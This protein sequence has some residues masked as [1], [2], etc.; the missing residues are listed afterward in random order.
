MLTVDDYEL[1]RRKHFI[2]RMSRRA[3]AR[4][5]GHSRKTVAKALTNPIPPGYQL[6]QPR[7]K[8][9]IDPVAEIIDA[10]LE[11]DQGERRRKQCHTAQ[12]IYER[13]CEDHQFKGDPS[14]VRRYVA[15]AKGRHK[16][17]FMLLAFEPGEEAQVDWHEGWII[18]NGIERSVQFFCMKLCYSKATFVWPYERANLESFL[19]GHVRAFEYFGGVPARLAYD[20]L[21]CAVIQIKHGKERRLNRQ[22]KELRSW[23]LFN[24]R[25]CNVGRGNEKGDVENLAKRSERTYLTPKPEVGALAEL[26]P[27]LLVD[28]QRDL[29]LSAPPPHHGK[30]RGQLF[31]QEKRCLQALPEH[32]FPAYREQ[33]SFIDKRSLIQLETNRYSAPVRWAHHP[34]VVKAYVDRVELWCEHERVATH[35]R[36]YA[37]DQYIL[38]PEHYLPLLRIKPGS[39]DNARPFKEMFRGEPW[40]EDF[41]LLRK[42]LEY[43]HETE[44][45]RQYIDVLLL[46][47]QWPE[48][49]VKRAVSTCVRRRA[50]AYEAIVGILRNEPPRPRGRLDLS[51]RP[52]LVTL[53]DGIR[54]PG[55]YDQLRSQQEVAP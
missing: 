50:F 17:V 21:K 36:C 33:S 24:T 30:T 49:E 55:I 34:V 26:G 43:R 41:E 45:T 52:A 12:R 53:G 42:E 23:Y 38:T 40:G 25:F 37:K 27:K 31:E 11:Q 22:F 44:G 3:I 51:D 7:A 46:F 28:C 8:P 16:E 48:Q 19:D 15:T 2:D 10:W 20:N 5:L 54:A 29:D 14:T 32:R 18:E 4:E 9:V 1:I 6:S 39:L 13:L 35:E 47:T